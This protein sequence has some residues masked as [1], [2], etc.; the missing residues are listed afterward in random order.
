MPRI[1]RR[2]TAFKRCSDRFRIEG[3]ISD[4]TPYGAPR[5]PQVGVCPL[6]P[7]AGRLRFAPLRWPVAPTSD[8]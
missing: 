3:W 4:A 5:W 6:G 1:S 7:P 2:V 8:L